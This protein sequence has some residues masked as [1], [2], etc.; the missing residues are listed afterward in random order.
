VNGIQRLGVL[1][2]WQINEVADKLKT[3]HKLTTSHKITTSHKLTTSHK[4]LYSIEF[5]FSF[6]SLVFYILNY[7]S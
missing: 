1:T 2:M 4:R 7:T 5:Q 3:S 6:L